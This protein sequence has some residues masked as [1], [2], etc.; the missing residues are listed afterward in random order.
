MAKKQT[1]ARLYS[2]IVV[3]PGNHFTGR[4]DF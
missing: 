4:S 1:P 2:G 3:I